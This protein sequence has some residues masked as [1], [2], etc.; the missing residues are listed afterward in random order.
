MSQAK[1][2]GHRCVCGWG[3]R[4]PLLLSVAPKRRGSPVKH[5]TRTRTGGVLSTPSLYVK[6]KHEMCSPPNLHSHQTWTAHQSQSGRGKPPRSRQSRTTHLTPPSP[7]CTHRPCSPY[8]P[9]YGHLQVRLRVN[10]HLP[11]TRA[12]GLDVWSSCIVLHQE[13]AFDP[14]MSLM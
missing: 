8:S 7:S 11:C 9:S 12:L 6:R 2:R 5:E 1:G 13:K 3:R 4:L 10:I 14:R